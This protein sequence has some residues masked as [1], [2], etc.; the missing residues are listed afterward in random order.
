MTAFFN[1][2]LPPTGGRIGYLGEY[3]DTRTL[4]TAPTQETSRNYITGRVG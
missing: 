3:G 1:A 2:A 4:F